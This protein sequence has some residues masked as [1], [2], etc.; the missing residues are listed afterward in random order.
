MPSYSNKTSNRFSPLRL[1]S[2]FVGLLCV[3]VMLSI[4]WARLN[5]LSQ[6]V[7]IPLILLLFFLSLGLVLIEKSPKVARLFILFF[8]TSISFV[9]ASNFKLS[10]SGYEDLYGQTLGLTGI[11][12]DDAAYNQYGDYEFNLSNL[13]FA[14]DG[15]FLQGRIR[16]RTKQNVAVYRGDKIYVEGK[17]KDTL[18][19]RTGSISYA[20]IEVLESSPNLLENIRLKFFSSVYSALPEPHASLGVGFL[21]GVRS[22]MTK[23][24]QDQLSLVGLTHIVAVSGYNLTVLVLVIGKLGKRLGKFQRLVISITLLGIFLL[25]TG[26]APSIVRAS[27]VCFISIICSFFGRKISPLNLILIS[28]ALTAGVNPTYL[29]EDL[30]WWLSFLAFFGVL[31]LAPAITNKIYKEKEPG[32]L[33]SIVIESISAQILT[34]P[35]IAHIFGTFSIIS[36]LANV[37]VI[38]LIPFI[39]LLVFIVGV[40]GMFAPELSLI[41]S[42]LPK[43]LITPIV[44]VIETLSRVSWASTQLK[45]S[46]AG[47]LIL[48]ILIGLFIKLSSRDHNSTHPEYQPLLLRN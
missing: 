48:Y 42:S 12:Q 4:W 34:A 23:E 36:L 47:M 35:L 41:L 27:V 18:G 6:K 25:I 17:L 33:M 15:E 21:A 45:L 14:E 13:H 20:K 7:S 22:S 37:L 28:A 39:M 11:V 40:V 31:I 43:I 5:P 29:W 26:F 24:F 10:L 46:Q 1:Q 32:F 2:H 19:S 38:P 8:V 16:I 30:G 9:C 44:W 3:F